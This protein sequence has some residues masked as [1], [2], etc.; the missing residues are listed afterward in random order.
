MKKIK[1]LSLGLLLA[2][3]GFSKQI[4][5]DK[6]NGGL[7]GYKYVEQTTFNNGDVY[8]KCDNPGWTGCRAQSAALISYNGINLEVSIETLDKIDE[9]VMKSINEANTSGKF[10][11]DNTFFV[12]YK[13]NENSDKLHYE[14]FL[15]A[16]AKDK[17]LI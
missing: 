5:K 14:I 15:I 17:G 11:F 6:H 10:I 3:S 1:L 4:V 13:Y 8:L 7:F 16:E 12:T 9:T 2:T